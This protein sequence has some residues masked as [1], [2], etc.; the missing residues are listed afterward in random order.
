MKIILTTD[1]PKVGNRYE[2]KDF[3]NGYA[4][5]LISRGLAILATPQALSNL[6]N[7]KVEGEKKKALEVQ[8]FDS[9]IASINNKKIEIKVKANE[10]GH[11]FKAVGPRD[12]VVA[13]KNITGVDIDENSIVMKPIKEIGTHSV[14]IK[15]GS[16][17]GNCEVVVI[18]N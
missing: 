1:V 13:I 9:L 7:K 2:V 3:K 11:L 17:K 4:N 8:N 15:K 16:K 10:K 14:E 5:L 6:A 18:K 12:V